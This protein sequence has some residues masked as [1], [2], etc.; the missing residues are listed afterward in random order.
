[1]SSSTAES[2]PESLV[3][4]PLS[5]LPRMNMLTGEAGGDY[6]LAHAETLPTPAQ[7]TH[8]TA[9][10]CTAKAALLGCLVPSG[11]QQILHALLKK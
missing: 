7:Q 8:W 5:C 10:V 6:D 11:Q 4:I 2:I 3:Q 9:A 1:M